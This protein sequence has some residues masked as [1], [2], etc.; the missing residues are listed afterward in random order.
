MDEYKWVT[1]LL[2]KLPAPKP[3]PEDISK[4]LDKFLANHIAT[5]EAG[6]KDPLRRS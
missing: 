3:I 2:R 4:Q 6:S 1:D 5:L